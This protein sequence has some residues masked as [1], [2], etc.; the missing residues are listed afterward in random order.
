MGAMEALRAASVLVLSLAVAFGAAA[1]LTSRNWR[2]EAE[3]M[4]AP[5]PKRPRALASAARRLLEGS[6]SALTAGEFAWLWAACAAVP[7]LLA[8]LMGLPAAWALALA[9]AGAVCPVAWA[10]AQ[11][12]RSR[13]RFAEDLGNVLPLVAANLR[14]GLSIRQAITPVAE[15]MGEPIKSE[16]ELLGAD[17]D[18]GVTMERA[19]AAMAE[20]NDNRDLVLLASGVATQAE[21]GGNLADI[22]EQIGETIRV[23][24]ELRKTVASKTSQQRATSV[25]LLLFP[26]AML[27]VFC[28]MSEVFRDFYLSPTGFAVLAVC[29]V[30]ELVG[31]GIVRKLADIRID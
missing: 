15:N 25:F 26:I 14:G 11:A 10:K 16:F 18:R 5:A 23:R 4:E 8:V 22:V 19:L 9:A 28:A 7:F 1:L 20:R 2:V 13:K 29:A 27:F 31:F 30:L 21:T 3:R 17:L 12:A 24:T 6:G